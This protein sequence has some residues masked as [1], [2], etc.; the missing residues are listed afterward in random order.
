LGVIVEINTLSRKGTRIVQR[1]EDAIVIQKNVSLLAGEVVLEALSMLHK[2]LPTPVDS[3]QIGLDTIRVIRISGNGRVY[4]GVLPILPM[5]AMTLAASK[6]RKFDAVIAYNL[7]VIADP[8]SYNLA[9]VAT[10]IDIGKTEI[11][12]VSLFIPNKC[13]KT[14]NPRVKVARVN[15]A[16]SYDIPLLLRRMAPV[17]SLSG[18]TGHRN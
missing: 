7:T 11:S 16:P 3:Q 9:N 6:D 2:Y 8:I 1:R 18:R 14:G 15:G 12:E 4:R 10:K 13:D 5:K 17:L